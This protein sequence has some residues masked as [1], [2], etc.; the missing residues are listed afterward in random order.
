MKVPWMVLLA[1]MIVISGCSKPEKK[2]Y[3]R[4]LAPGELALRKI[5]DPSRM[6]DLTWACYDLYRLAATI[7]NSLAYF[8]KPSSKNYFPYGQISYEKAVDS[9]KAIKAMV[10]SGIAASELKRQIQSKFDIYESVGCDN[11]GTVLFTGYYTPIFDGSRDKI[12]GDEVPVVSGSRERTAVYKYPL[13]GLPGDLVKDSEGNILG[14]KLGD[15]TIDK[16]PDRSEIERSNMLAGLELIWLADKFDVYIAHVQGSAKIRLPDGE[17]ITLGYAGNNGHEYRS[18]NAELVKDNR[19][20]AEEINLAKMISFF[21]QSP[22]LLDSYINKNPRFVFF[23]EQDTP[24]VGSLNVE[25]TEMRTIATDKTVYPRGCLAFI[26]TKLPRQK[27]SEIIKQPFS[28]FML[29]QDTG[30]AIRAPGRCD[31]YMG[32]GDQAGKLAGYTCEEGRLYYLFL[33]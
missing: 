14:R 25:V 22:T 29:D 12:F 17:L 20:P 1:A 30:G 32:V 33:K 9:L 19:I 16:Y 8:D 6:P 27:G 21:K 3:D 5:T 23:R 24:P 2:Q 7:D 11:A 15:G 28:G 26:E 13:Y 31:I 18:I 4:P 10:E